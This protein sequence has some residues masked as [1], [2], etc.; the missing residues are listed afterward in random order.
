[1]I[2]LIK[3]W[4]AID[5]AKIGRVRYVATN[6]SAFIAAYLFSLL[7]V[8]TDVGESVV[9]FYGVAAGIFLSA[10]LVSTSAQRLRDISRP[11]IWA[12]GVLV[13]ALNLILIAWLALAPGL[14]RSE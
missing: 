9:G 6:F 12:V 2:A 7:M 1:M 13:P 8:I 14:F 4:L 3:W 5:A 11:E 10:L